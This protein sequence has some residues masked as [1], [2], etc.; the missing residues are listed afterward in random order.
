MVGQSAP[1]DNP[2]NPARPTAACPDH[3]AGVLAERPGA[4][5]PVRR[6]QKPAYNTIMSTDMRSWTDQFELDPGLRP[7]FAAVM[8]SLPEAVRDEL[9]NDA[10][11]RVVDFEPAEGGYC[12]PMAV[13]IAG[14][15]GSRC[16]VFKRT[17]ANRPTAFIRYVIAHE[18]AHAHLRNEGRWEGDDPERAADVLAAN[19]GWPRP[20]HW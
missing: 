19:W 12:V 11:F 18:L 3:A 5:P 7:H 16:V 17:L 15:R 13:P 1:V 20:D 4:G 6:G 2:A 8:R 10:A 14:G 9:M